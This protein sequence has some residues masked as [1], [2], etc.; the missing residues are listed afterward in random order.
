MKQCLKMYRLTLKTVGPVFIGSGKEISKKEYLFLDNSKV[1]ILD[2]L[3]IYTL[4]NKQGKGTEYEKYLLENNRDNMNTWLKK[5]HIS[6]EMIQ[7]HIKYVLD[8]TDSVIENSRRLQIMECMKDPYGNPYIPGSSLKGMLRT[9]LLCQGIRE[10]E[11]DYIQHKDKIV[12]AVFSQ[13][14]SERNSF[15]R[16]N[17]ANIENECFHT[18]HREKTQIRDAVND[19]LQGLIVSDSEPLSIKDIVLCQRI[20]LHTQG[21]EKRLP[22]LRE[23]I[24]PGTEICFHVTIDT[25]VCKLDEQKIMDAVKTFL[26]VYYSSFSKVFPGVDKLR[27]NQVFLGGGCGFVSKTAVYPL[28]RRKDGLKVTKAVFH[29]TKVPKVHMHENDEKYGASPHV[30]KCTRYKGKLL[31]IG[32]CDLKI[33]EIK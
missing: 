30:L 17:I 29:K 11:T 22:V 8:N 7:P 12:N 25:S 20:E 33:Q 15:L 1:A 2:I 5:Q 19:S 28:F 14:R 31:Q 16:T 23:C 18:I 3:R 10:N 32:L 26:Q 4:L 27:V 6:L 9:I 24:R 21:Q 13:N